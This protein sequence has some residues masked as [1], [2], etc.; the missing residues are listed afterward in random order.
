MA[1]DPKLVSIKTAAQ[2]PSGIP[3]ASGE[4][5]YFEDE[6]LKKAEM[7]DLYDRLESAYLGILTP[8][9]TIPATGSWY[10]TVLAAGIYNNVSPA[11]TVDAADFDVENG[12]ANNEVRITI[13]DGVATKDVRRVK[14]DTGAAGSVPIVQKTG[15]STTDAMSQKAVTDEVSR[16]DS[17][18]YQYDKKPANRALTGFAGL[19]DNSYWFEDEDWFNG[20]DRILHT[21][22]LGSIETGVVG[23]ALFTISGTTAT[24]FSSK[25]LNVVAG[26]NVFTAAQISDT[27]PVVGTQYYVAFKKVTG[28]SVGYT[29][30]QTGKGRN[31][32][33]ANPT[34]VNT[35]NASLSYYLTLRKEMLNSYGAFNFADEVA[36]KD[37]VFIPAGT[38][39]V[40]QKVSLR[41]GQKIY[42]IPGK[43]ILEFDTT[44]VTDSIEIKDIDSILL[45]GFIVKGK[46]ANTVMNGNVVG[47]GVINSVA[48]AI[49]LA[50]LGTHNGIIINNSKNL[51]IRNI[52]ISNFNGYGLKGE[53][54]GALYTK[55][56]K[57]TDV[58]IHDCYAGVAVRNQFEYNTLTGIHS[59]R[60][61]I[62]AIVD[63]GNN[64]FT[65]CN[66][67]GN[68]VNWLFLAGANNAHGSI[69]GGSHNH[70]SL[71]GFIFNDIQYG[72]AISGIN[73]WY[74]LIYLVRSRGINFSGCVFS[75]S[76]V[77][78]DGIYSGGGINQI[79]GSAF[80]NGSFTYTN[81]ASATNLRLKN[82]YVM[83]G[84][85]DATY[86]N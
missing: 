34:Q 72:Q 3:T 68:R 44:I 27:P 57:F 5:L 67:S 76:S 52:E 74:S 25:N 7:S 62:G 50:G 82:N 24:L 65:G 14:G 21:V 39:A 36:K 18:I 66:I 59:Y 29:M 54:Y 12:T 33:N 75:S 8:S 43:S 26:T 46:D 11:I 41:S 31:I 15:S 1:I 81:G 9:S 83:G 32:P 84:T 60:C 6:T 13:S 30:N 63:A 16:I 86:N 64:S 61:Q 79:S 80:V 70:A 48:N 58:T 20:L 49:A 78:V 55:T 69:T 45:D 23:V 38:H 53:N 22:T 17:F 28:N 56:S 85:S 51:N 73:A 47:D 35:N 71:A 42:G 4:F 2:L 37:L 40:A 19:I 10:G 77:T